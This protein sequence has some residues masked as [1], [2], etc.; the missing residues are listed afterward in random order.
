[1]IFTTQDFWSIFMGKDLMS[2]LFFHPFQG[3]EWTK[4]QERAARL[5]RD[6][7]KLNDELAE[8]RHEM[9]PWLKSWTTNG[10]GVFPNGRMSLLECDRIN[11]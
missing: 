5:E 7:K 3:D 9:S 2:L 6:K 1:M 11:R 8:R 4:G 10:L